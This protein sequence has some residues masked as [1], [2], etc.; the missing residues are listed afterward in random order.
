MPAITAAEPITRRA[1]RWCTAPS[2]SWV[3]H[4]TSNPARILVAPQIEPFAFR[5]D[6]A[7]G[8][9]VRQTCFVSA[10]DP[11]MLVTWFRDGQALESSDTIRITRIDDVTSV[12]A[13]SSLTAGMAGNYTCVA[14]NQVAVVEAV[15]RLV[16]KGLAVTAPGRGLA[17]R[18][19]H[20]VAICSL[21]AT[22]GCSAEW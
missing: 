10:G 16:V 17:G 22:L 9:G 20:L 7:E 21:M 8:H 12:L 18:A 13:I 11:P 15:A 5:A 6:L 2:E 19:G 4:H 3:C 1:A 14:R